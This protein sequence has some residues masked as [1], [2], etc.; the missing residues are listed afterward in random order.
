MKENIDYKIIKNFLPID[1]FKKL[2]KILLT[3]EIGW[4]YRSSQTEVTEINDFY[5]S[6][7]FYNNFKIN[8]ELFDPYIV[9]IL[10]K[11]DAAMVDE[12][13]ANLFVNRNKVIKS[14]LHTDRKYKNGTTAILYI[15]N[16][17]GYTFLK[18]KNDELK[19]LSEENKM[20]IFKNEIKHSA[21]SQTDIAK[22]IIININFF[23]KE[24]L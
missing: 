22:R 1:F 7:S 3:G 18:D 17:N 24:S 9:P 6:H 14:K 12:V 20:L 21:V 16:N 2:Q 10:N 13:R 15:N 23:K 11:L 19:V 5:F 8:S 4:F